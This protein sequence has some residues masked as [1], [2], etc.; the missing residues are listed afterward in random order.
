MPAKR[1]L[2]MRQIRELLR[3]SH[4]GVGVREIAR[5][6]GVALSTIHDNLHRLSVN[7]TPSCQRILARSRCDPGRQ[8]PP[9]NASSVSIKNRLYED[10]VIICGNSD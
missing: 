1:E 3:L 9:R 5:R 7:P 2:T 10:P 4:E 8:V 6:L